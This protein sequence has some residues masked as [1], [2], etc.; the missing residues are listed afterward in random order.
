[1]SGARWPAQTWLLLENRSE[2]RQADDVV[3]VGM[4]Q[5]KIE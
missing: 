4:G 5:E 1:M 2:E 3:V